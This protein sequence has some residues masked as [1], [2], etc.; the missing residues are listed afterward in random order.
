MKLKS[1]A[2]AICL[3]FAFCFLPASCEPEQTYLC[4][5]ASV[6]QKVMHD[7]DKFTTDILLFTYDWKSFPAFLKV[8]ESETR[9]GETINLVLDVHG[10]QFLTIVPENG[11]VSDASFGYVVSNI[12]KI[13]KDRKVRLFCEACFA[14][15]A[16]RDSIRNNLPCY[17]QFNGE[18]N[19]VPKFPIYGIKS[20]GLSYGNVVWQQFYYNRIV[21]FVDLRIYET[22]QPRVRCR[23]DD[24]GLSKLEQ[25][26]N[27]M[28]P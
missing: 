25:E 13:L 24:K 22:L 10:D 3:F 28:A 15:N 16:Y 4:V 2:I 26:L 6:D 21:N 17:P 11:N 20:G 14:G 19:H 5:F 27:R 8:V 9:P 23:Q 18:C 1:L 7:W 12:E